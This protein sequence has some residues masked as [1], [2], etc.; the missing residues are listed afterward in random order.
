MASATTLGRAKIETIAKK[1]DQNV[2]NSYLYSG[3]RRLLAGANLPL[4]EADRKK[5]FKPSFIKN[6]RALYKA[7]TTIQ[8]HINKNPIKFK[9]HC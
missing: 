5:A 2:Q 1:G 7:R 9:V 6:T 3:L 4:E 8:K